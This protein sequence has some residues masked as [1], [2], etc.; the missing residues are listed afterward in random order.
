MPKS[1][2]ITFALFITA[3][4]TLGFLSVPYLDI[5]VKTCTGSFF[6]GKQVRD[7]LDYLGQTDTATIAFGKYLYNKAI[8]GVIAF[9]TILTF[10]IVAHRVYMKFKD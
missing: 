10:S 6:C 7:V 8:T 5:V 4:V 9:L 2:K 1:L 3:L